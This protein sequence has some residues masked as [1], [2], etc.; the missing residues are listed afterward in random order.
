MLLAV[1][2]ARAGIVETAFSIAPTQ[3]RKDVCNDEGFA[4]GYYE[5]VRGIIHLSSFGF[6]I[7][8]FLLLPFLPIKQIPEKPEHVMSLCSR[9]SPAS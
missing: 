2:L 9:N 8:H 4:L 1:E 3:C 5:V 6:R 7:S